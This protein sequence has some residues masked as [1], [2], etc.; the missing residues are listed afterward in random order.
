MDTS[1]KNLDLMLVDPY[2]ETVVDPGEFV[3]SNEREQNLIEEFRILNKKDSQAIDKFI[4]DGRQHARSN[5]PS[6][7][8]GDDRYARDKS[9]QRLQAKTVEDRAKELVKEADA[10]KGVEPSVKGMNELNWQN[11]FMHSAM[12]DENY[13]VV[14]AHVDELTQYKIEKGEYVDFA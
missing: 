13:L 11:N 8:T 2:A 4:S 12:V 3:E 7:S 14:A 5:E 1:D 9:Q 10:A 6:T